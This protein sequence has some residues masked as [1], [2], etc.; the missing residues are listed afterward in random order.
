MYF[1][2][3]DATFPPLLS[4]AKTCL[5]GVETHQKKKS[6]VSR[7]DTPL[8]CWTFFY[9]AILLSRVLVLMSGS[10]APSGYS[11]NALPSS[12]AALMSI[13]ERRE[14]WDAGE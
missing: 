4:D 8:Q 14:N 7:Q 10:E 3:I 11:S 5:P 2:C 12:A 6:L 13:G 9:S 1:P